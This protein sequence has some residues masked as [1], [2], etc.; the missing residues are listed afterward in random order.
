MNVAAFAYS[1]AEMHEH[2]VA[3]AKQVVRN[4]QA[5]A[6][7]LSEE[8]FKVVAEHKGFTQSHQVLVKTHKMIAPTRAMNWRARVGVLCYDT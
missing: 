7:A 2:G 3:Y 5:L 6:S 8:G 4:A 1:L